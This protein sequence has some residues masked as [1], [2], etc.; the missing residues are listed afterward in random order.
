MA[1]PAPRPPG[2]P[3]G[4]VSQMSR[5]LTAGWVLFQTLHDLCARLLMTLR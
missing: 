5:V 2:S 1:L 4:S 3:S